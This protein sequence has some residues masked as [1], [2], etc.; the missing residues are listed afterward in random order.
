MSTSS[1]N[2]VRMLSVVADGTRLLI[3]DSPIGTRMR[4]LFALLHH[5]GAF[6]DARLTCWFQSAQPG[7]PRQQFYSAESWPYPWD[8]GLTRQTAIGGSTLQRQLVLN[9]RS[10]DE[11]QLP[12]MQATYFGAAIIWGGKLWGVI[13]FRA[14]THTDLEGSLRDLIIALRPQ[15]AAA[16]AQEGRSPRAITPT[17]QTA[18]VPIRNDL[19]KPLD[20]YTLLSVL[21]H[22]ALELSGAEAGAIARVDHDRGELVLQAYEGFPHDSDSGVQP[23]PRQRWSWEIGLAGQAARSGRALLVRDFGK[24][25]GSAIGGAGIRAEMATPILVGDIPAAVIILDSPR[26]GAFGERELTLIRA[27]SEQAAQPLSQAIHYQEA[28]ESSIHLGQVFS[29]MP[30]GLALLDLNG[31]VLR[32]NPAWT[33]LWGLNGQQRTPFYVSIDLVELLLA[34]LTDPMKLTEFCSTGQRS[35]AREQELMVSLNNPTQDLR[36]RSLPTRDS[37]QQITGRIWLVTDMTRDREIDRMKNEFVSIVSHELRTPLT[38][39]LGYTEL[40]LNRDFSNEEQRQFITTVYT[41]AGRLSQLVEDLLGVSRLEAGKVKLNRWMINLR[42]VI[43]ELTTQLDTQLARHRLL[44]SVDQELPPVYVDRDKVKQIIFNLLSNAIKY[45]PDG[46]EIVLEVHET[47]TAAL[48]S[49]HARGRWIRVVVRDEGI[50]IAPEDQARIWERFYRV[51]N[52]NTRR[53]GGTGLGLNITR[54]LVELHGGQI[55]LESEL[56]QGSSFYFTLPVAT[57]MDR[58]P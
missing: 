24:D 3:E 11:S 41:E 54:A 49:D 50:G 45:S 29:S 9:N 13:E 55:W 35:P 1:D 31:Q 39:I 10:A 14:D 40:L 32:S 33:D 37:Q 52:T 26:S 47:E 48:P 51:D 38:S 42:Q 43:N 46:G 57:E 17:G 2:A 28:I 19:N 18:L 25:D 53:I 22:R 58:R 12:A 36:V 21:L 16:I 6:R 27:L 5:V 15:L 8:D 34:R 4:A 56:G 44:F 7:S 20:L 23:G 30:T